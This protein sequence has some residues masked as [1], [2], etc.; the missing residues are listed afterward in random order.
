M[1]TDNLYPIEQAAAIIGIKKRTLYEWIEDGV[2][3]CRKNHQGHL[4]LGKATVQDL[5]GLRQVL[6]PRPIK[7]LLTLR[8]LG[9]VTT[10]F[11]A[12]RIG[13]SQSTVQGW[14]HSGRLTG[15]L[16]VD[17]A[18]HLPEA[19][20]EMLAKINQQLPTNE[21]AK[22]LDADDKTIQNWSHKGW[23]GRW[24]LP[25]GTARYSQSDVN[26][27]AQHMQGDAWREKDVRNLL[28]APEDVINELTAGTPYS[29]LGEPAQLLVDHTDAEL[30]E[31]ALA[32]R[33]RILAARAA[34]TDTS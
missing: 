17:G 7:K 29:L 13:V 16:K 27:W 9:V 34:E 20:M 24:T 5:T 26:F 6:R 12:Q 8:K 22:I 33:R 10:A 30:L 11:A 14:S 1:T 21:A 19:L 25:S 15:V 23:I 18:Y 31:A 32:L 4:C 28:R 3:P 2:I